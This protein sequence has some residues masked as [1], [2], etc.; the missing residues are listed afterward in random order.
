MHLL[1]E[2]SVVVAFLIVAYIAH[3]LRGST[4]SNG[5][6]A[7]AVAFKVTVLGEPLLMTVVQVFSKTLTSET[8]LALAIAGLPSPL[9]S[10]EEIVMFFDALPYITGAKNSPLPSP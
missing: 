1:V 6:I 8:L 4:Y 10:A 5:W 9:K 3:R 7:K 2:D